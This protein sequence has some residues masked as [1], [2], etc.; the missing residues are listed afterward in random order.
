MSAETAKAAM[1]LSTWL[2][3]NCALNFYNKWL[4]AHT[5]FKFPVFF[6]MFH[7]IAQF[8]GSGTLI[9]AFKAAKVEP[10]HWTEYRGRILLLAMFFVTN[11]V[12]NN[13]SLLYISLSVN[14]IVKS[15]L[16]LPTMILSIMFEGKTY[17][18]DYWTSVGLIIGGSW[19]AVWGNP[20]FT[21]FG[22][23]L[24]VTSTLCVASWTILS[25]QL[26]GPGDVTGLNSINLSFYGSVP[27]MFVL[28]LLWTQID[29]YA[30]VLSFLSEQPGLAAVYITIGSV[31]AF[32]YNIF[33]FL[34]IKYT[35]TLTS[36]IAGNMK[37]ILVILLSIVFLEKGISMANAFGMLVFFVGC[38]GYSYI[39]KLAPKQPPKQ[40]YEPIKDPE[41]PAPA[42]APAAS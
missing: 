29:E 23:A 6:T 21:V 20:H 16:P 31:M 27:A 11:I 7:M 8:I 10:K 41:A 36:T 15:T 33:H 18:T 13:W 32:A 3:L 24:V 4:F 42:T 2:F 9:Y 35:S 25:A 5:A 19:L 12:T 1:C 40:Q 28:L 14:Q 38:V 22:F 30:A 17:N 37:I 26:L 39:S 34:L